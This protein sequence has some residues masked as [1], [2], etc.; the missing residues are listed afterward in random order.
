[1]DDVIALERS[2]WA[3]ETRNDSSHVDRLL[4]A[5]YLEIGSSGRIWRRAEILEPVGDFNAEIRDVEAHEL[6]TDVTLVTYVS[7]VHELGDV[8]EVVRQP[9]DRSSLWL[10]VDGRWQLRF[11]QG[12][13]RAH[14]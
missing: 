5:D 4:H 7:I 12:T 8:D 13:P 11:H 1:M 6:A 9:V 3:P 14:G 10:H 2:L